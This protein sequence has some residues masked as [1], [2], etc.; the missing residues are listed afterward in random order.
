VCIDESD[1]FRL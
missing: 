1:A